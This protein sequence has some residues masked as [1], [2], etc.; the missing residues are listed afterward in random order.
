[1]CRYAL[2]VSPLISLMNDQV[3]HLNNTAGAGN[4]SKPLA[5][6][7][8]STQRDKSVEEAALR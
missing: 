3:T 4:Q 7:L 2:V 5:A 6:F 8:G 1:V